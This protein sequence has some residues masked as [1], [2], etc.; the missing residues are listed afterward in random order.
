MVRDQISNEMWEI[1]NRLYLYLRNRDS[2]DFWS[3]GP[4][5]FSAGIKEFILLFEGLTESTFLHRVGY[6]FIKAGKFLERADKTGRLV[7]IKHFIDLPS[8]SSTGGVLDITQW[9]A[10]L[11]AASAQDAYHQ[12][13]VSDVFPNQVIDLLLFNS[14]FPRSMRFCLSKLQQAIHA[15]SGCPLSHFSNEAER[16]CGRL[17]SDFSYQKLDEIESNGGLHA[18][19]THVQKEL[20]AIAMELNASYM[21][22]PIVDPSG[23]TDTAQSGQSMG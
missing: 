7:D 8:G 12:V 3:E 6:E 23:S 4:V 2:G 22:F 9:T 5:D 11:R 21:F 16:R 1:I 18:F 15:I 20:N 19:L 14:Q 10:I 17:L 13:Y